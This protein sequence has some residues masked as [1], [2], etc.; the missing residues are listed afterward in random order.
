MR[1]KQNLASTAAIGS[2]I[3]GRI[4]LFL[5]SPLMFFLAVWIK[6][7]NPGPVFERENQTGPN[8]RRLLLLKFRTTRCGD[9]IEFARKHRTRA[10]DFL[11][12]TRLE[13]LPNLVSV[14]HGEIGLAELWRYHLL[15]Q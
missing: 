6:C 10:G 5:I 12:Y 4:L 15:S 3:V 2:I 9:R 1:E 11:H 14:A 7:D 13:Y 8:G